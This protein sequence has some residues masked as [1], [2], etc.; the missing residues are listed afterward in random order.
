VSVVEQDRQLRRQ[1]ADDFETDLKVV[2]DAGWQVELNEGSIRLTSSK[3]PKRPIGYWHELMNT[4]LRFQLPMEVQE[5]LIPAHE[6]TT[7]SIESESLIDPPVGNVIRE[8]RKAKGWKRSFFA[9]KMGKSV[10]W[11][12]AVETG[13]RNCSQQDLPKLLEELDL[14]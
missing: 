4:E 14:K 3:R 9:Q 6:Y 13:R 8:A 10:S 11:V 12:D 7:N 2:K 1:M 5:Y